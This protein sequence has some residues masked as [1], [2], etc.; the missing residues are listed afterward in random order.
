MFHHK[1]HLIDWVELELNTSSKV[2]YRFSL[3]AEDGLVVDQNQN[4]G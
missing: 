4:F 2:K 1:L 3:L